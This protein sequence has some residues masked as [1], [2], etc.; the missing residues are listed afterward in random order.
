[1]THLSAQLLAV[2][3][4]TEEL[5]TGWR[6]EEPNTKLPVSRTQPMAQQAQEA[7]KDAD[8]ISI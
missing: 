1:M 4:I 2:H 5:P 7:I 6:L 8:H 3:Q